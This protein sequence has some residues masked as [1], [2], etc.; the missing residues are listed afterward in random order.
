MNLFIYSLCSNIP[1]DQNEMAWNDTILSELWLGKNG[2][3]NFLAYWQEKRQDIYWENKETQRAQL[4]TSLYPEVVCVKQEWCLENDVLFV[5]WLFW[6]LL[7][8]LWRKNV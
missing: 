7:S 6:C 8:L 1:R 5:C 2:W 4:D 3:G